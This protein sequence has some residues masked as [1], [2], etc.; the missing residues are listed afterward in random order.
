MMRL[1]FKTYLKQIFST[2]LILIFILIHLACPEPPENK[3]KRDTTI[4]LEVLSTF[5][6]TARL[7]ISVEDTTAE[8]TFG[9]TRNGED[10]LTATVYNSDTIFTDGGLTPNTQYNYQA[11][12][13]EDGVALDT[14]LTAI[15]QTMDTTS[16]NFVWEIDTLG[17]YGSYLNDVTIVNE[18]DIWVVGMI[19]TD[20]PDTVHNTSYTNYNAAH[21]DGE[22]WELI[23]IAPPPFV[24]AQ[25]TA[26][27]FI[28]GE[29]WVTGTA[30]MKKGDD[31]WFAFP[32]YPTTGWINAIW[33]TS[34]NNIYFV[35]N[36]GA[37]VHYDGTNFTEMDSGT[38]INLLDITGNATGEKLFV[39]GQDNYDG[40]H[41][42][43]LIGL[44]E[45]EWNIILESESYLGNP[46]EGDYGHFEAIDIQGDTLFVS[47]AEGLIKI[48]IST[49]NIVFISSYDAKTQGF[50]IK[51]LSVQSSNDIMLFG[52]SG[53]IVHYN[54]VY[55]NLD[56]QVTANQ[57]GEYYKKGTIKGNNACMV[58]QISWIAKVARGIRNE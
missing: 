55:W 30:P 51:G 9:L 21:W 24:F 57:M 42:S 26:I 3:P 29:L 53:Q 22:E 12:W 50:T 6:T 31:G 36:S 20:E 19:K 54:G 14:S 52:G 11:Q 13:I 15:A 28:N 43:I 32:S 8:W 16:H 58:G 40:H 37:I 41:G 35:G 34:S 33:G 27:H 49:G 25:L 10:V 56:E 5:T 7:H 17:I 44:E 2:F 38:D 47:A 45:V 39:S 18:N 48:D 46:N 23:Q 4:H 1:I